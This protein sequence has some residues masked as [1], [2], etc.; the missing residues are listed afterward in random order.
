MILDYI[1]PTGFTEN[2]LRKEYNTQGH[3]FY[4]TNTQANTQGHPFH[5]TIM[6]NQEL[7]SSSQVNLS[8]YLK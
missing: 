5:I 6:K 8:G 4:I 3:P 1:S 2:E 7:A